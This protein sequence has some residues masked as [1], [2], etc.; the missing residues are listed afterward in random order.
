LCRGEVD[1]PSGFVIDAVRL[2][3]SST[4]PTSGASLAP[5]S[6]PLFFVPTRLHFSGPARLHLRFPSFLFLKSRG[7]FCPHLVQLSLSAF[8]VF[9][10]LPLTFPACDYFCYRAR[11]Y[12]SAP[13]VF[14]PVSFFPEIRRTCQIPW[15]EPPFP[16]FPFLSTLDV[17]EVLTAFTMFW[18]YSSSLVTSVNVVGAVTDHEAQLLNSSWIRQR[19]SDAK[20]PL[21]IGDPFAGVSPSPRSPPPIVQQAQVKP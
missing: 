8:P 5:A 4:P 3:V 19:P 20:V 14:G 13:V 18:H 17:F 6:D 16:G 11:S 21:G 9:L 1:F 12:R 7:V 15:T 2:G 10:F